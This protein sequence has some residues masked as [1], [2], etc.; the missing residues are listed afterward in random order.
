MKVLESQV[1]VVDEIDYFNHGGKRKK[2]I[3]MSKCVY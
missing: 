1:L 3:L 2:W